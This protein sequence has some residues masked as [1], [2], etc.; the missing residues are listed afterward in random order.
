MELKEIYVKSAKL[1]NAICSAWILHDK[2]QLEQAEKKFTLVFETLFPELPIERTR[3]AAH[4]ITTA[5]ALKDEFD[6]VTRDRETRLANPRWKEVY[7]QFIE[8]SDAL[9][10][11]T[12]YAYY[13]TEF[14]RKHKG[15]LDYWNDCLTAER[16]FASRVT[17]N[18]VWVDK[19]R[20]GINGPGL[21]ASLYLVSVEAHDLRSD[22]AWNV[23]RK[24][25]E[26]YYRIIL[27]SREG[28]KTE[29]AN[30]A[31]VMKKNV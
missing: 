17:G 28:K 24:A 14:W 4:A 21:L 18:R 9:G 30:Q 20:D 22:E 6:D 13:Y 25:M 15:G 27:L 12:S 23:A 7:N 29:L 2:E 31:T 10:L 19:M 8:F 3:H 26:Q 1:A 11:P 5:L 16:I